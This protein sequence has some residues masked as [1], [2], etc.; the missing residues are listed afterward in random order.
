MVMLERW[1]VLQVSREEGQRGE[2]R[3]VVY[4]D[5]PGSSVCFCLFMEPGRNLVTRLQEGL[6][7]TVQPFSQHKEENRDMTEQRAVCAT[8]SQSSP[9]A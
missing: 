9:P 7:N 3:G 6:E 1:S 4:R 8:P 5:S 2:Q